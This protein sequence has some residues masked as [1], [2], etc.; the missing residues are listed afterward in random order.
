MTDA[1][2]KGPPKR[3]YP[4]I[5]GPLWLVSI[6]LVKSVAVYVKYLIVDLRLFFFV[7][8]PELTTPGGRFYDPLMATFCYVEMIL[9]VAGLLFTCRVSM[10]Y[11]PKRRGAPVLVIALLLFN[12]AGSAVDWFFFQ[13]I[14]LVQQ[15]SQWTPETPLIITAVSAGVWIPYFMLSRRVKGTFVH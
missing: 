11:F 12:L 1:N 14:P 5:G 15:V 3:Y 2:P 10:S 4:S 7:L 13:Q 9:V 8:W 6:G